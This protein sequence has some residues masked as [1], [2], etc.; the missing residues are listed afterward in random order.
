MMSKTTLVL[1]LGAALLGGCSKDDPWPDAGPAGPSSPDPAPPPETASEPAAPEPPPAPAAAAPDPLRV[2]VGQKVTL[3]GMAVST[4]TGA[5]LHGEGFWVAIA[6]QAHWQGHAGST[7]QVTGILEERPE[8]APTR[9]RHTTKVQAHPRYVLRDV[10]WAPAT[11]ASNKPSASGEAAAR[12]PRT[13]LD[14]FNQLAQAEGKPLTCDPK[15]AAKLARVKLV[16][17]RIPDLYFSA[18]ASPVLKDYL[19]AVL[20]RY[21]LTWAV[22][23][24]GYS[25]AAADAPR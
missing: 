16:D 1:L 5:L 14:L 24:G 6:N 21:D 3:T 13:A 8:Q 15:A 19:D 12:K 20:G 22:D 11:K 7:V 4:P 9:L 23:E 25:I 10:I 17:G 2:L 18:T